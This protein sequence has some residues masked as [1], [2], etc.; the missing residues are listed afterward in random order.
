M[1]AGYLGCYG[2]APFCDGI[3]SDRIR[4]VHTLRW[5]LAFNCPRYVHNRP[6]ES[7]FNGFCRLNDYL[8]SCYTFLSSAGT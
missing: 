3:E 7:K 8:K 4:R 6:D 2:V 5:L 1:V